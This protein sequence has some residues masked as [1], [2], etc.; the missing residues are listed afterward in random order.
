MKSQKGY[1]AVEL[2]NIIVALCVFAFI[3]AFLW[4]L[5]ST[6]VAVLIA[7]VAVVVGALHYV[8]YLLTGK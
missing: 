3:G 2:L 8:K 1:T 6:G 5:T 4:L 7:V